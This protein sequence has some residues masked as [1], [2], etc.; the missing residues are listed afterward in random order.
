MP[1]SRRVR[2]PWDTVLLACGLL[3][4]AAV[5][6][7]QTTSATVSGSVKDS[8]GAAVV[9]AQVTLTSR[10]QGHSILATTGDEGLFVLPIVRADRYTLRIAKQGFR[11]A[12]RT[13]VVVGPNDRFF[14]GVL[15][16]E[17]GG[18]ESRCASM[19]STP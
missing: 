8:Q 3:A 18:I 9:G 7:A 14:T 16:L 6:G 13:N 5:L 19:H 12:E 15:T 10:T 1:C 17:V 4:S 2:R 11:T